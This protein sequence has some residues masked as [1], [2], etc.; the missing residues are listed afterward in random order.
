MRSIC[1]RF[2]NPSSIFLFH[3]LDGGAEGGEAA[4]EIFVAPIYRIHLAK[5]RLTFGSE[6]AYQNNG[7]GAKRGRCFDVRCVE[8]SGAVDKYSMWIGQEHFGTQLFHLHV[9]DSAILIYPIMNKCA[10]LRLCR[11]RHEEWEIVD[12]DTRIR[13]WGDLLGRR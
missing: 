3:C 4:G 8:F 11:D 5:H 7:C 6:H 12:V 1:S 2:F 9:I 10:A 13:A